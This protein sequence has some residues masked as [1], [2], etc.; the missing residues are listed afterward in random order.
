[1]TD[2]RGAELRCG[3]MWQRQ[4]EA[5]DQEKKKEGKRWMLNLMLLPVS[6]RRWPRLELGGG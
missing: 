3:V 2:L 1:M 6:F 5:E 4:A